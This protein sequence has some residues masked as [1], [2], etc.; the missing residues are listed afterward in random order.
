MGVA[1][2]GW[3]RRESESGGANVGP[4]RLA[5]GESVSVGVGMNAGFSGRFRGTRRHCLDQSVPDACAD[6]PYCTRIR[7]GFVVGGY[8][9]T[10]ASER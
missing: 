7:R 10:R 2:A 4:E 8:I 3:I 6:V 9:V 5:L 1:A